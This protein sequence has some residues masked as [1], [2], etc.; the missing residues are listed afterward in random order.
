MCL[1][2]DEYQKY[3]ALEAIRTARGLSGG[4]WP[5]RQLA[6]ILLENQLLRLGTE[7]FSEFDAVLVA[8]G[9]KSAFGPDIPIGESVLQEGFCSR[10]PRT[11][12][13]ELRKRLGRRAGVH[14]VVCRSNCDPVEWGYFF[15][16][17]RDISK[18]TL[19]RYLFEAKEVVDEIERK[20]DISRGTRAVTIEGAA[21]RN[22]PDLPPYEAEIL[23]RLCADSRIYWVSEQCSSELN[24]LVEYPLTSAVAVIKPPGSE[25]EFEIKR[26]GTR[27]IRRL[28][29]IAERNGKEAP[30]SHRLFGGSL[31]WLG[32]REESS[33][34]L[35]CEIYRLVHGIDA[36]CSRTVATASVVTVSHGAAETH[37]LDYLTDR[38]Q[39]GDGFEE[40]RRA[41]RICVKEFP[42]DTGVARASYE[43]E[44]GLTLQF[45][46]QALP[47]QAIITGS[48]SFRLDR[49][50][51]YLSSTGPE[52]YFGGLGRGYLR[53]DARWLADSIL[54]EILG[55]LR[56]PAEPFVNYRQYVDAA[57]QVPENRMRA[58][59]NYLSVM[60]QTGQCWGTLL[61]LRGFSDGESFVQ[62]NVGLR[63]V[64]KDGDWQIRIIFMDHDDLTMAG[65]R[66]RYLWPS[67]E[68]PGMLRDQVHVLG[69]ALGGDTIPGD[70]DALQG[71][72][73]TNTDVSDAGLRALEESL[74]EAYKKTGHQLDSNS[75]M[76][77]LFY[78]EFIARHR[79]FDSLVSFCLECDSTQEDNWKP[80]AED[81]LKARNYSGELIAEFIQAIGQHR[82]F[83][84][85]M[86]FLYMR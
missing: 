53:C 29:V 36:P 56:T 63:S 16:A 85:R 48:S 84:E 26:A 72:Y 83:F 65:S 76:Q 15:R 1:Q 44:A 67:R 6:A 52:H 39:F 24:A 34:N 57:F 32:R 21:R 74:R 25:I 50:A 18:L 64:W 3:V 33:A 77:N 71:I 66:Y 62:R 10:A 43:G 54:E 82:P 79:D 5:E 20:L 12:I 55:E 28:D 75:E 38:E 58:D 78:P 59:A 19:A 2:R 31:G 27:G 30:V 9:L 17:A 40:T 45:I 60:R 4:S 47:Q 70:A 73:R 22:Q 8:I 41:M 13:L 7:E 80:G 81:Y 42:G 68:I 23:A 51:V 46:G 49:I 37:I 14:N 61:A 86:S 11:F 69:G 35:F